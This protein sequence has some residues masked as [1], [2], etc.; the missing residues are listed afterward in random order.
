MTVGYID[1][2]NDEA[3]TEQVQPTSN[4]RPEIITSNQKT[5]AIKKVSKMK[6]S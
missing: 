5:N 4:V 2:D 3:E 6:F 1:F